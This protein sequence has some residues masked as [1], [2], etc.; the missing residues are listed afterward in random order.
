[1]GI[2]GVEPC[3]LA[4]TVGTT[5]SGSTDS[6]APSPTIADLS[7]PTRVN[8]SLSAMVVDSAP[9]IDIDSLT[10]NFDINT[11]IDIDT[12]S[13]TI[14]DIAV[15]TVIDATPLATMADITGSTASNTTSPSIADFVSAPV[16]DSPS[17]AIVEPVS[18]L[19]GMVAARIG[20]FDM[21]FGLFNFRVDDNGVA[22]LISVS[23]STPL[24]ADPSTSPAI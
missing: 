2:A 15:P 11:S 17:T 8:G 18:S 20:G 9:P 16:I 4:P 10:T 6:P 12:T 14:I 22:E 23:D 19:T 21:A 5:G 1:M 7:T 3:Q 13:T 24:A